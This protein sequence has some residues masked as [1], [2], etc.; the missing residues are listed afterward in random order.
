MTQALVQICQ[1]HLALE[2]QSFTALHQ[3]VRAVREA[4]SLGD[5]RRLSESIEQL[6]TACR[7]TADVERQR[8][9][10]AERLGRPIHSLSELATGLPPEAAL[11]VTRIRGQLQPLVDALRDD[12]HQLHQALHRGHSLLSGFIAQ[13]LGDQVDR[14]GP[15]GERLAQRESRR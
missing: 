3:A 12:V 6:E 1:Q 9:L 15:S 2:E 13:W 11:D 5:A 14:Y 4:W 7:Q 10:L 8:Q